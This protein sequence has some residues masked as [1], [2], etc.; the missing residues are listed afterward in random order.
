MLQLDYKIEVYLII[1]YD[2]G[3]YL[4]TIRYCIYNNNNFISEKEKRTAPTPNSRIGAGKGR[5][6]FLLFLIQLYKVFLSVVLYIRLS[7][8]A[9]LALI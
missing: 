4:F 8:S 3:V 5:Q 9:I 6:Y 2:H 7:L 1:Q